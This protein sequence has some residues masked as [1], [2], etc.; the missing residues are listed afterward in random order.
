MKAKTRLWILLT[1][2]TLA[3]AGAAG[4]VA[5]AAY[6]PEESAIEESPAEMGYV[7]TDCEGVIGVYRGGELILRTDVPLATLRRV[8]REM[9]RAGIEVETY[10]AL[11]RL[12]QDFDE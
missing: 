11:M 1:A 8:D 10:E 5:A 9:L 7:L 3:L 6:A 4:A 12:L 2:A